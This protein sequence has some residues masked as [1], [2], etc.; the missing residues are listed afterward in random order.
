MNLNKHLEST[1]NHSQIDGQPIKAYQLGK[2][3]M[4]WQ[5][6]ANTM[7]D[8]QDTNSRNKPTRRLT[9]AADSLI[10]YFSRSGSTELLASK[11]AKQTGAD[12]L[13]IIVKN[14]YSANYQETLVRANSERELADF[15]ELNMQ[16]PNLSQYNT[17]YLGYPIWAMTFSHPMTA[18]LMIHGNQLVG[19]RIAPFMTEGGYGQGDSVERIKAILRSSGA[20]SNRFTSALVIDGNKVDHADKRIND[21]VA[22][23]QSSH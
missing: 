12:L 22:Q 3:E 11:V 8:N 10:I 6:G 19:K 18:F 5:H 1:E 7:S 21:W 9:T 13:E 17:I 2:S 4:A 15:P 16:V 20:S 14:S 23:I